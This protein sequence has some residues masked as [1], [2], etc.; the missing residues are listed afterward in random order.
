L[1]YASP[2]DGAP[3][4]KNGAHVGGIVGLTREAALYI[5]GVKS[6]QPDGKGDAK[7]KAF[8]SDERQPRADGPRQSED[9]VAR[10][11]VTKQTEIRKLNADDYQLLERFFSKL[12]PGTLATFFPTRAMPDEAGGF[13]LHTPSA[14]EAAFG[15]TNGLLPTHCDIMLDKGKIVALISRARF[16]FRPMATCSCR[17]IVNEDYANKEAL[18]R[19]GR[20][21]VDRARAAGF[22]YMHVPLP[23]KDIVMQIASK[24]DQS[25]LAVDDGMPGGA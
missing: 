12:K 6:E 14:S 13:W 20:E 24:D 23:E 25:D 17:L 2:L 7:A 22:R 8:E 18:R 1:E 10:D 19:F 9:P 21:V 16:P 11:V 5:F 3:G 15:L 4:K